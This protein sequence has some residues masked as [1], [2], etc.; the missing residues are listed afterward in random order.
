[1][2]RVVVGICLFLVI[3]LTLSGLVTGKSINGKKVT[4]NYLN[5]FTFMYFFDLLQQN[6]NV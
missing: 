5:P 6:R 1:M 2:T 3:I 4:C